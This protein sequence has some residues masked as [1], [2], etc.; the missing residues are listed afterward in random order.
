MEPVD[1]NFRTGTMDDGQRP[2]KS[3]D[4]GFA[5]ADRIFGDLRATGR[6]ASPRHFEFWFNYKTGR[7]AELNAAAD[8]IIARNGDIS[9]A[10]IEALSDRFLSA[11]RRSDGGWD[12][13]SNQ[14]ARQ[15]EEI[16]RIVDEAMDSC[17][18]QRRLLKAG[19]FDLNAAQSVAPQQLLRAIDQLMLSAK[20]GQI[21]QTVVQTKLE[22]TRSKLAVLQQQ[23]ELV[24]DEA[25]SDPMTSLA[26]RAAFD[27]A[28]IEAIA[29]AQ[30]NA[31][32]L[33]L[34]MCDLDYFASFVESFGASAGVAAVR[35][36]SLLLRTHMGA[37]AFVAQCATDGLGVIQPN[38]EVR[39]AVALADQFRQALMTSDIG[40]TSTGHDGGRLTASIGVTAWLPGDDAGNLIE[41]ARAGLRIAKKE[42]RNRVVE[43]NR[44][45]AVWTAVRVA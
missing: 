7:C 36:A 11:W 18:A 39:M 40:Q 15:I 26:N 45:G 43:M 32:P 37:G 44:Q 6:P 20:E 27:R 5:V 16:S 13:V 38:T 33:A 22:A 19:T 4:D 41:R 31:T 23:L 14:L 3:G 25:Q 21:R 17:A 1:L 12:Q 28:L 30:K 24:R 34:I 10:E 8:E 29:H 42:G 9:A 35:A 2:P